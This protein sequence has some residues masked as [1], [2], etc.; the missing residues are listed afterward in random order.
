MG[1]WLITALTYPSA[2]A[3]LFFC[4]RFYSCTTCAFLK[5]NLYFACMHAWC[6]WFINTPI[7]VLQVAGWI[8]ECAVWS[9]WGSLFTGQ[10]PP[11]T[12]TTYWKRCQ[13]RCNTPDRS[14]RPSDTRAWLS[15]C[16]NGPAVRAYRPLVDSNGAARGSCNYEYGPFWHNVL[17][18]SHSI[19]GLNR[20]VFVYYNCNNILT[21]TGKEVQ[22]VFVLGETFFFIWLWDL[23]WVKGTVPENHR[24]EQLTSY[25]PQVWGEGAA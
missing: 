6:S 5:K 22:A 20:A 25:C 2:D 15:R 7:C 17:S 24:Q 16:M 1:V 4:L 19:L 9:Q 8:S 11:W 18:Y 12:R 14:Q 23:L 21:S 3:Y 13:P 10:P